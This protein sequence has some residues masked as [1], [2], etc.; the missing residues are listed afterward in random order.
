MPVLYITKKVLVVPRRG[1]ARSVMSGGVVRRLG[2]PYFGLCPSW[3]TRPT[4]TTVLFEDRE[5][6]CVASVEAMR[7]KTDQCPGAV[8]S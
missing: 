6:G 1:F 2:T 7:S 8:L 5:R 3:S 4:E